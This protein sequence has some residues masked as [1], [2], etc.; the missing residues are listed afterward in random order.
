MTALSPV[1]FIDRDGTLI[2]EPADEQVD[3]LD[4]VRLVPGVIP[5]LCSLRDAG[6]RFVLVSNQD[7]LGTASFPEEDF[8]APHEFMKAILAS[9]GIE[10]DAEFIC[11]HLPGD[12]CACRKPRTGLLD[13]YLATTQIDRSRSYVIGDRQTD[14][15][16]AANLGLPGLRVAV[17]EHSGGETWEAIARRLARPPRRAEVHRKTRETDIRVRV[18]LDAELPIAVTTGLGF[19]DHMLEQIAKHGGFALEL[20]C[21]GDLHIDEHHTVEDCALALGN[22]LR[23]AL[24]DKRGIARYGFLLP[25]DESL[26]QV[27]IDLSGRPYF[28][29]SGSFGRERVGELPTELVPHFFRSLAESLGAALHLTVTGENTHHMIE[30]CFKGVG[31]ALRQA[32]RIEGVELP[33]SKGVL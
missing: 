3:R 29:F 12:G 25:M 19:F 10:F 4:K 9:Q 14:L 8:R 28:V 20:S 21:T 6:F 30:A 26:A 18:N 23:T 24:G 5:A 22:A 27:A 11:P 1:L 33:S 32:I 15:E 17:A 7:G 31:R 2:E 16:L 13:D